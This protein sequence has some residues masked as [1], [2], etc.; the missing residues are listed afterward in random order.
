MLNT[1]QNAPAADL[2]PVNVSCA[3]QGE[4][5]CGP[6]CQCGDDC[7]CNTDANCAST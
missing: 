5:G 3:T 1:D 2:A 4:C 6:D 7:R